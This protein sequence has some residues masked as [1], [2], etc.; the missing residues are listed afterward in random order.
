MFVCK[1]ADSREICELLYSIRYHCLRKEYEALGVIHI[2]T[3]ILAWLLQI[4]QVAISYPALQSVW[5]F[6][7]SIKRD[8]G[9][10]SN[11]QRQK[12]RA[13][14]GECAVG[15]R[16]RWSSS[17][18][19]TRCQS[20]GVEMA[21]FTLAR[22]RFHRI[23]SAVNCV[24]AVN[25]KVRSFGMKSIYSS[26]LAIS[27]WRMFRRSSVRSVLFCRGQVSPTFLRLWP[28]RL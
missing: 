7:S 8:L 13:E 28:A 24:F 14:N 22:N 18:R 6:L 20:G 16:F 25:L 4:N 15:L 11:T 3:P 10:G 23:M 19:G 17:R 9:H 27:S 5:L 12:S 2:P 21:I 26:F 1:E